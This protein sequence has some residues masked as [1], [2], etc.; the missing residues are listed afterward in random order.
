MTSQIYI[1]ILKHF[2]IF[3]KL[4]IDTNK[5]LS[6]GSSRSSVNNKLFYSN[7]GNTNRNYS[8]LHL[9]Y[10]ILILLIFIISYLYYSS[11]FS[12]LAYYYSLF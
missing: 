5:K 4:V 7:I 10:I 6:R 12:S 9:F 1:F 11:S 8:N 2:I 3:K